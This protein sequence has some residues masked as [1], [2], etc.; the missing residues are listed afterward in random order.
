MTAQIAKLN[1]LHKFAVIPKRW[2]VDRRF[3]WLQKNRRSCKNY[4]R[5][6]NTSLQLV[7]LAF[8]KLLLRRS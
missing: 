5:L 2:L 7:H 4:V 3:A 6:I 8:L 1:E